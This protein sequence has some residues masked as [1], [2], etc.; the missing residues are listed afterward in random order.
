MLFNSFAF[1]VFLPIVLAINVVVPSRVRW[2]WLL[3]ASLAFY[4]W[5]APGNLG[6][7]G[8][9]GFAAYLGGRWIARSD[10]G[11]RPMALWVT[12]GTLI[13]SLIVFKFYDPLRGALSP[14][15]QAAIPQLGIASPP[16]YSFYVFAAA[17]YVI[18]VFRRPDELELHPG[19]FALFLA[20]F[21]K[22]LVGPIER[23][24]RFL[25][26][27]RNG[28][29]ADPGLVVAGLHLLFWGLFKKVVIADNL[30]P[31]V[32]AAFGM[33]PYA[34]PLELVIATYFFAFQIYCDFSGVAD[35]AIGMS[36]LFGIR[37]SA[38]FNRP[39][40]SASTGEFWSQRWHIT[41][42]HWFR[43][44][45]YLPLGGS[46]AGTLRT[47][48]NVMIVFVISGLWHAGLGYGVGSGFI[49]WG[50]LNGAYRWV[51]MSAA[52]L[53]K[54]LD[55]QRGGESRFVTGLRIVLTFHL[56]LISWVF[57]RAGSLEDG[58]LVLQRIALELPNLPSVLPRYP[59]TAAH[60]LGAVLIIGLMAIEIAD[61]RRSVSERILK[62]RRP[63]RWAVYCAVLT[64]IVVLGRWQ[65]A[66]FIYMQF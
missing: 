36:L 13:G 53:A 3:T 50:A 55:W 47:Y 62:W 38:N 44:Y 65:G 63:W 8:F 5:G 42:G 48:A 28:L 45:L 34:A 30:S 21:P 27:V 60:A 12:L 10:P 35:M 59:F 22:V 24:G 25:S 11:T 43:D 26:Q 58:L 20:W 4:G 6:F 56:I 29:A 9:A 32:D 14:A 52:S 66:R 37:L 19:R 39:Y 16:G 18:D 31:V 41:L 49:V 51:E 15:M 64:A 1:A 61:E 7:L 57:F 23:S 46:R 54:V 17:A 33:V 2:T 40:L